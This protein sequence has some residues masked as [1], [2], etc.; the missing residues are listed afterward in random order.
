MLFAVSPSR[1]SAT[2]SR[3]RSLHRVSTVPAELLSAMGR[4]LQAVCPLAARSRP[5][6]CTSH[7]LC[8]RC[9]AVPDSRD[10]LIAELREHALV[11]GEV[12]LTSG[13]TA[14]YYVDAK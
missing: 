9:S 5:G 14:Q 2:G 13:K 7:R 8:L 6:I 11:I 10:T 12:V 4:T 3:Q 1:W